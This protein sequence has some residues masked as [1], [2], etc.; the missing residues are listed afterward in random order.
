V[1]NE[2]E[3]I[4]RWMHLLIPKFTD[5]ALEA[6]AADETIDESHA[7]AVKH[8]MVKRQALQAQN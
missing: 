3:L 7:I 5:E 2:E 1:N 6:A 4:R 8:E